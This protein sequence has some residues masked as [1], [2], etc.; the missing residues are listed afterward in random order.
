MYTYIQRTL[1]A[2]TFA[3]GVMAGAVPV[4]AQSEP[5]TI[6]LFYGKECPHCAKEETFLDTL[7]GRTDIHIERYEVWHNGANQAF[8]QTVANRLGVKLDGVPFTVVGDKSFT[9]W[10]DDHSSDK[11]LLDLVEEVRVMNGQDVVAEVKAALPD[12]SGIVAGASSVSNTQGVSENGFSGI[13]I[14]A[15]LF[16]GAGLGLSA[17]IHGKRASAEK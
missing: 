10:A 6:Y 11:R 3:L 15:L 17:I 14:A 2:L 7:A 9:G 16:I 4:F 8:A 5:V 13:L 1:I 12:T